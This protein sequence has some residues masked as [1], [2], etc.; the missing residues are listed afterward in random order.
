MRIQLVGAA[1]LCA[2][3]CL[4]ACGSDSAGSSEQDAISLDA[5]ND[6]SSG[7]L[8]GFPDGAE[9][10]AADADEAG[11]TGRPDVPT[12]PDVVVTTDSG[13]GGG[14]TEDTGGGGG[15]GGGRFDECGFGEGCEA[16]LQCLGTCQLPCGPDS[17][18]PEGEQCTIV[19]GDFGVCSQIVGEGDDCESDFGRI[20]DEDLTCQGGV[21]TGEPVTGEGQDCGRG[22]GDDC[23]DGLTCVRRATG[24]G[25]CLRPCS[26]DDQCLEGEDCVGGGGGGACFVDCDEGDD[27]SVCPDTYECREQNGG[28]DIACLPDQSGGGGGGTTTT[29]EFGEACGGD[30]GCADGLFCPSF[31]PGAYCVVQCEGD[32]DCPSDPPGSTCENFFIGQACVFTCP[33]GAGDCPEGMTCQDLF[34]LAVCGY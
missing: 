25:S 7:D 4:A 22:F 13:G 31:V 2:A 12:L 34:G 23:P 18:C 20:C 24:G 11:G 8:F 27:D 21:C 6:L 33:G 5:G 14:G 29:V 10:D 17:D 15:G 19:R 30:V 28:G 1:C 16:P 26:A 9:G 3:L 32:S